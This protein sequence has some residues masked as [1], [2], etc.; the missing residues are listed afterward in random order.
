MSAMFAVAPV[1]AFPV[2]DFEDAPLPDPDRN[3]GIRLPSYSE[4]GFT[5]VGEFNNGVTITDSNAPLIFAGSRGL[6]ST[7]MQQEV[8]L[9][10]DDGS[11]FDIRSIELAE[12]NLDDDFL[13]FGITE[14]RGLRDGVEVASVTFTPRNDGSSFLRYFFP[15]SFT[16]IDTLVFTEFSGAIG[17]QM[18][19][20]NLA[21]PVPVPASAAAL[22]LGAFVAS[23]R[24][25]R[26]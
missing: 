1:A 14:M 6:L 20:L 12:I 18:D 4:D 5:F 15:L 9:T 13:I 23:A 16:D 7:F 3:A 25:R 17:Y 8:R 21:P 10:E 22:G 11:R 24:S 19:N 26:R 2:I